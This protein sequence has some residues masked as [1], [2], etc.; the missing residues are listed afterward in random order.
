[1][2]NHTSLLNLFSERFMLC[3]KSILGLKIENKA[4]REY[5]T[6]SFSPP[7]N[8]TTMLDFRGSMIGFLA[9]SCDETYV[10]SMLEMGELPEDK[11]ELLEARQ[12]LSEVMSEIINTVAGKLVETMREDIPIITILTPKIYFTN[13]MF[14]PKV[15]SHHLEVTTNL[16]KVTFSVCINSMQQDILR[17]LEDA[18]QATKAKSEFL[19]T[20][21]HEIRTPINGVM[22]MA[23]LL[24]STDQTEEQLGYSNTI[25]QSA[26][27]LLTV[28]NDILDYSKIEVG[29]LELEEIEFS[30]VSTLESCIHVVAPALYKKGLDIGLL[31]HSS[32]PEKLIGDPSRIRQII[33]NFLSN[34]VKFTGE[35]EITVI[36]SVSKENT[37]DSVE[38]KYEITDTGIGIEKDNTSQLFQSFSQ[39]D[40]STTRKYG[41]TG[42]GLAISKMLAE[43]MGGSIGVESAPGKGST[44]W[45]TSIHRYKNPRHPSTQKPHLSKEVNVLLLSDNK[46]D[47]KVFEHY[48]TNMNCNI[49]QAISFDDSLK[50]LSQHEGI[51]IVIVDFENIENGNQSICAQFKEHPSYKGIPLVFITRF[52]EKGDAKMV[53]DNGFSAYLVKPI[54]ADHMQYCI[55]LISDPNYVQQQ[56]KQQKLITNHSIREELDAELKVLVVEDNAVNQIVIVKILKKM[57]FSSEVAVNGE[58]A[59]KAIENKKFHIVFMDC[60]MPVMN[61]YDATRAIRRLKEDHFN[62]NIIIIAL[63][64]NATEADRAL[65]LNAGMNDFLS[66]PIKS[67]QLADM[68]NKWLNSRK[69]D[70]NCA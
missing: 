36:A 40:A 42:L 55:K 43:K 39:V 2:I 23:E 59:V 33:L 54:K 13:G 6:S 37:D 44:F 12:E 28:I 35:G 58:E 5:E 68:I 4:Q 50:I 32:V 53:Q 62:H 56:S 8:M 34:A 52:G 25:L 66:K 29:K 67:A 15:P 49:I 38:I 63:T 19:A 27:A 18:E 17:L 30:L 57:G 46:T 64:A 7:T 26:D 45:F 61:G 21:S 47:Y 1:M 69:A 48:F 70:L 14:F 65:C 51:S 10:A 20:M 22:G 41:G 11:E 16:G 3:T 24:L 31:I 60:Q 9:L